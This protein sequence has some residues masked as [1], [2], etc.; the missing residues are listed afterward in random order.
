MISILSKP[1]E[2]T[3]Y[4]DIQ[5]LVDS[6]VQEGERVE[7]KK[8]LPGTKKRPDPWMSGENNLSERAKNDILTEVVAFANAYGGVLILGIE[9]DDSRKPGV[10]KSICP[11]PNSERLAERFRQVFDT[12]VEPELPAFEIFSVN[13]DGT[14][15]GVIVFRIPER[16]RLAPHGI[17][18]NG[19]K[20]W[21]CPIRRW[22]RCEA[23]SMREIQNMTLNV[24]RGLQRLDDRLKERAARFKTEF[25]KL[26]SPRDA[27]GFRITAVPVSG[28]IR[29]TQII[30]KHSTLVPGLSVPKVTIHGQTLNRKIAEYR[31]LK[32][33]HGVG[34]TGWKP[35]L[36]AA[37]SLPLNHLPIPI[38]FGYLE[39]HC[40]GL[41]EFGWLSEMEDEGREILYSYDAIHEFA[42]VICWADTL[43]RYAKVGQAE[44]AVQ[45]AVHVEGEKMSVRPG[46]DFSRSRGSSGTL[47][48]GIT[49]LPYFSLAEFEEAGRLL[50]LLEHDLCNAAGIAAGYDG[51]DQYKLSYEHG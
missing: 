27:Y 3:D 9:E 23:M 19:K 46:P 25:S 35:Q 51:F 34:R 50:S 32:S 37:R 38:Y 26:N 16:S 12:M 43:R 47:S 21:K 41:V 6:K 20:S 48:Q 5:A 18:A 13:P 40:D 44:Y 49:S 39:I 8:E 29:L 22:D 4:G 36:R 30:G 33:L 45:I 17:R 14:D 42:N 11:I 24:N 7:F 15:E 1:H 2:A 10:A 31:G 28:D